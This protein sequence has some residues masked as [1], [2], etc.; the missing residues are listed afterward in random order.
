L[1][2]IGYQLIYKEGMRVVQ[3]GLISSIILVGFNACSQ[4]ALKTE[5][6]E[7]YQYKVSMTE[8][9]WKA[10]LTPEQYRVLREKGTERAFTGELY[11]VNDEGVYTCAG[12][13]NELFTSDTKY[14][15]GSGW[16]SFYAPIDEKNVR[17]FVDRSHGMI[18]TEVVC[19]NCGGHLGHVFPDG[20]KPTGLRY[21]VN[22]ASMGFKKKE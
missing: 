9:E 5:N 22:S 10:K 19:G 21:C 14:E 11:K 16:P 12:C 20:P 8:E 2:F 13:D 18:R 3:L 7:K 4:K 15:S 1:Q 17:E 6:T